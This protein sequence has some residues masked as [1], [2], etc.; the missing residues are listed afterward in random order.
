MIYAMEGRYMKTFQKIA[1]LLL[2][3]VL[4]GSNGFAQDR[5]IRIDFSGDTPEANHIKIMGA[6]FGAIPMPDISFGEIPT[7]NGFEGATDGRGAIVQADP[8]EGILLMGD[9]V[10]TSQAA[11][12]RCSVRTNAPHASVYLASIDHGENQFIST[13][14]PNNGAFFLNR[15]KRLADFYLPPSHGFQPLL[16]VMNTSQTEPLTVYIDNFDIYL[17]ESG[18]YYS[19]DFLDGNESDPTVIAITPVIPTPTLVP[20]S[21]PT[22]EPNATSTPIPTPTH[23]P[24]TTPTPTPT[25]NNYG[26]IQIYG[27]ITS[28][29]DGKPIANATITIIGDSIENQITKSMADG[30]YSYTVYG[31]YYDLFEIIVEAEGYNRYHNF[32]NY[33]PQDL[34]RHLNNVALQP[35]PVP[36]PTATPHPPQS[37][38][39][40]LDNLPSGAQKLELLWI[41]PGTFQMG[42]PENEIGR[43]TDEVQHTV[44]LTRGFYMGKY[45]VTQAQWQAILNTTPS[46]FKGTNRPVEKIS[47]IEANQFIDALNAK[48]LG[49]FRLPTEAEWE[50]ACRAGTTTRYYWGDDPNYTLIGNYAWFDL[51]SVLATHDVGGKL[52]NPWGLFDMM[53]NVSE[54]CLDYYAPYDTANL[55]NP[56]GPVSGTDRVIRGGTWYSLKE[57]C[58]SA[59]RGSLTNYMRNKYL[60]FRL[61]REHP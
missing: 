5:T 15:Y 19:A 6:G 61:V 22:P 55:I 2:C 59:R 3:L 57:T 13:I 26:H 28:S 16:Q 37:L 46:E 45:E 8:G 29:A 34:Y 58:R 49:K 33:N 17:L 39:I 44:T 27:T 35:I 51:N 9:V 4:S 38:T 36:T 24:V 30:T 11:I 1:L 31:Y 47:W 12:L 20:T 23:T 10:E 7:D 18:K 52:A 25:L 56:T 14:T 32:S 41:P 21:T 54:W 48:G 60:G 42:S 50:Y 43:E 53:G 40:E